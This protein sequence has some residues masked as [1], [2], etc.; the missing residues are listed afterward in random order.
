VRSLTIRHEADGKEET[1][2]DEGCGIFVYAGTLPTTGLFT[3][4][5]LHDGYI[6]VDG[7]QQTTIP[8]VF[9]A[10]DIC[11]KQVRQVATAVSD[12]A[13]AAINAAAFVAR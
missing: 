6:P 13:V 4:L 5:P 11:A 12:G 2:T 1:I 8:G 9:A 10:G 7:R 3:E